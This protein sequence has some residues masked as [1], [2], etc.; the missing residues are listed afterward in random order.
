M[1]EDILTYLW[2][3]VSDRFLAEGAIYRELRDLKIGSSDTRMA[4]C[5]DGSC[6]RHQ[7]TR[8]APSANAKRANCC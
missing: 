4:R 3:N 8:G 5:L 7:R 6:A 1:S 2:D